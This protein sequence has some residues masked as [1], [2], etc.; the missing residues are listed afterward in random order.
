MTRPRP[1]A[2]VIAAVL[3]IAGAAAIVAGRHD[4]PVAE[5]PLSPPPAA[6]ASATPPSA[7][8]AGSG[9]DVLTRGRLLPTSSPTRVRIPALRIDQALTGLG[10]NADG[11][12]QV[13]TDAHTVGWYTGGPTPGSLGPAVLAGHVDYH[14]TGGT[15]ARLSTLHAG[16][17]V[18][19]TRQDGVT[20]VFAVTRVDR[21][22][23]DRFP[24]DAVYGAIDHAGLRLITCGGD[25]D[26][27]SGHYI[28]NIVAYAELRT[29]E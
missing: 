14:G 9:D 10:Q 11:S 19:V 12:M 15:F 16:D 7:S 5:P 22:A 3:A 28:D 21:Y 1:S 23:K 27:R 26:R 2:L 13:P 6:P 24:A 17:L 18:D 25:F 8:A 4:R 20:A 29:T